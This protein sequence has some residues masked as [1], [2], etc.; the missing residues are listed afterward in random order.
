M[1]VKYLALCPLQKSML[2]K[3]L[4][5]L[6][7]YFMM[8]TVLLVPTVQWGGQSLVRDVGGGFAVEEAIALRL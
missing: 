6:K 7:P 5:F 3:S 4:L 2:F 1:F 8:G